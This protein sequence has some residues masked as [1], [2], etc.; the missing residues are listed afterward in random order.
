[1]IAYKS[2]TGTKRITVTHNS[3]RPAKIGQSNPI[4][5]CL[6]LKC[7]F[8]KFP[9]ASAIGF[10][11]SINNLEIIGNNVIAVAA[12]TANIKDLDK[13]YPAP[14]PNNIPI[15]N[16]ITLFSPKIPIFF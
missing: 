1:M 8:M 9:I 5:T 15:I 6:S 14:N 16:P 10:N 12:S 3:L 11:A 4:Y 2:S 7:F 13:P